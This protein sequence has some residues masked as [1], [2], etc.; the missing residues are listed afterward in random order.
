MINKRP[1]LIQAILIECDISPG[2]KTQSFTKKQLQ[3]ILITLTNRRTQNNNLV[4]QLK[5]LV[6]D[7]NVERTQE[8]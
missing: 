7:D 1:E 5:H 6:R 4:K 2:T 3:T 8:S